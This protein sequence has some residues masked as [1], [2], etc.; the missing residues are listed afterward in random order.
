MSQRYIEIVERRKKERKKKIEGRK[1]VNTDR[2]TDR[3]DKIVAKKRARDTHTD[4][5][6]DKMK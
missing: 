3:Q 1:R 5:Q 4:R 6:R 2:Q